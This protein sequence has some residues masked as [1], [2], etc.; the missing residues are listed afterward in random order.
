M[1]CSR[2]TS[3]YAHIEACTLVTLYSEGKARL[4]S[5][6]EI[7][8]LFTKLSSKGYFTM[9]FRTMEKMHWNMCMA[10]IRNEALYERLQ[11]MLCF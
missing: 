6:L 7:H 3:S 8:I 9:E 1:R 5:W 10:N 11:V 4:S 2:D